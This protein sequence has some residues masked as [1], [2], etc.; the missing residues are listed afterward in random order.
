MNLVSI[1]YIDGKNNHAECIKITDPTKIMYYVGRVSIYNVNEMLQ[2]YEYLDRDGKKY[3]I[4]H[5]KEFDLFIKN[6]FGTYD[7]YS[8]LLGNGYLSMH[9]I[10]DFMEY[11][12]G[13]NQ[14]TKEILKDGE[15][16]MYRTENLSL[17]RCNTKEGNKDVYFGDEKLKY[18]ENFCS[19]KYN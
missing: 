9:T 7:S 17:I 19:E 18:K 3:K 5:L 12:V 15:A 14:G 2:Y 13:R 8:S 11:Q 6:G 10:F 16:T 4:Y 1:S